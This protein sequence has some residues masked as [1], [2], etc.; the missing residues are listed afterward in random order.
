MKCIEIICLYLKDY[1]SEKQFENIFFCY[2]E[3]FE[4]SLEEDI[5]LEILST[6]FGSKEERISLQSTLK[7]YILN[8]YSAMLDN[9]NDA[10]IEQ[11]IN[12]NEEDIITEILKKRYEIP[13]EICMDCSS[14][15][16]KEELI[17]AVK[18]AL[19]Y[20][21]FCGN[22]WDAI[23]DLFFDIILPKKIILHHWKQIEEKM[24]YDANILKNILGKSD[25][26][27]CI[28]VYE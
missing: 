24:P 14:I 4:N 20:P 17:S 27:R 3:L 21:Q 11:K 9:I 16:S 2:I 1:I 7:K 12:L 6:N 10:Y 19:Q 22:N 8:N 13:K 25:I 28:I 15:N 5:Y 18:K 26:E 23:E